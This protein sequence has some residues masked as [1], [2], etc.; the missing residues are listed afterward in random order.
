M[1]VDFDVAVIGGGPGGYIAAIR[2]AQL[3][4]KTV[5]IDDWK[6]DGR[7]APG[8]TC[9]N[10][11]CIPSKA[12]L[13]SSS[14]YELAK[15]GLGHFG[16]EIGNVG[17]DIARMQARRASIVRQNNDGIAFLFRKNKVTFFN[18]TASFAGCRNGEYRMS[19]A[20]SPVRMSSSPPVRNPEHG[21]A[22]RSM[23]SMCFPMPACW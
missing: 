19:P 22:F 3:G 6:T 16:V 5:C 15:E 12:L 23:R 2:A 13:E 11:G 1:S 8:G 17:L 21:P 14:H 7:P 20:S 18:G 9:T 10:V 4:M